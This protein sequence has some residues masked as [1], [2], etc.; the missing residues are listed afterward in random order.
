VAGADKEG[1]VTH[2]I[3]R[4]KNGHRHE[5]DFGDSP[6][7]VAVH[8]SDVEIFVVAVIDDD[9]GRSGSGTIPARCR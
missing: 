5:V 9:L 3:I 2:A 1:G 6:V 7:R 8:A 4:G